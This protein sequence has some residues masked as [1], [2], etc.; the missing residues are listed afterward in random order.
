M[1]FCDASERAYLID[2]EKLT[3]VRLTVVVNGVVDMPARGREA[4]GFPTR[5]SGAPQKKRRRGGQNNTR[6][7]VRASDKGNFGQVTAVS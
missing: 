5:P 7:E 4:G 6:R 1:A 3:G 2:I